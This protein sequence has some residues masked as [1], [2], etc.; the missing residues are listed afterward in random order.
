MNDDVLAS[1]LGRGLVR[2]RWVWYALMMVASGK[3][4]DGVHTCLHSLIRSPAQAAL[5]DQVLGSD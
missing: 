3:R 5:N 4:L 2:V 1:M